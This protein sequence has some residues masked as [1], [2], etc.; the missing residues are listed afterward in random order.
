MYLFDPRAELSCL[1]NFLSLNCSMDRIENTLGTVRNKNE[2]QRPEDLAALELLSCMLWAELCN[3]V[4][5]CW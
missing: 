2:L 3:E 1:Y 4:S 5:R